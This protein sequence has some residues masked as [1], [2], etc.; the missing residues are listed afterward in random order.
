MNEH[1]APAKGAVNL[2]TGA[3]VIIL[4]YARAFLARNQSF[5]QGMDKLKPSIN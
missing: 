2:T 1:G 5:S 4:H 3:G